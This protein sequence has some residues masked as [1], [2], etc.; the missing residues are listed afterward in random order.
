MSVIVIFIAFCKVVIFSPAN[1][2]CTGASIDL[3]AEIKGEIRVVV[4]KLL[5]NHESHKVKRV[6]KTGSRCEQ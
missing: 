5:I 3:A 4:K 2:S 6:V 1:F